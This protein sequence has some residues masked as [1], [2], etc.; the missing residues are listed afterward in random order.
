MIM[1]EYLTTHTA[2]P[3]VVGPMGKCIYGDD[4]PA[5][6]LSKEHVLPHGLSGGMIL[7]K[8]SCADCRNTTSAFETRCLQQN[9][10]MVRAHREM[11]TRRPWERPRHGK[12][13]VRDGEK[14]E[15][16]EV[17]LA[18]HPSVLLI[19]EFSAIP[20]YLTGKLTP[21]EIAMQMY[22]DFDEIQRRGK[23]HAGTTISVGGSFDMEAFVRL[24][25]KIGH[26]MM[27]V[28]FKTE[29]IRPLLLPIIVDGKMADASHLIGAGC[30]PVGPVSPGLGAGAHLIRCQVAEAPNHGVCIITTIQL[31]AEW[32]APT[33]SVICGEADDVPPMQTVGR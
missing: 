28:S 29:N 16:R 18:E 22:G 23:L 24:L 4:H 17:P 13:F 10:G 19:P 25:A 30:S 31:F 3:G 21:P 9:F 12:L 33:Y 6:D 27:W 2:R 14:E 20:A 15:V 26:G 7:T 32:G 1:T 8:A 5:D 11:P